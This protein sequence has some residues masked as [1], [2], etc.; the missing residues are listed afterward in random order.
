MIKPGFI[1][2]FKV[3]T[4]KC[5]N[6]IRSQPQNSKTKR[7]TA[8]TFG[9]FSQPTQSHYKSHETPNIGSRKKN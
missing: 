6:T 7:S 9:H 1:Y 5:E 8:M 2:D 4:T 3:K